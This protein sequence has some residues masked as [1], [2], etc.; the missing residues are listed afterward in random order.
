[1]PSLSVTIA[2]TDQ[3]LVTPVSICFVIPHS[4]VKKYEFVNNTANNPQTSWMHG[5]E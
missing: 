3:S 1:M 4:N 2:N 5:V